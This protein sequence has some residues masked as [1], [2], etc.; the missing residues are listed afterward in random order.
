MSRK[1]C[2]D[3]VI[4]EL[5]K[6]TAQELDTILKKVLTLIR[7]AKIRVIK[8]DQKRTVPDNRVTNKDM[9]YA[10]GWLTAF[11]ILWRASNMLDCVWLI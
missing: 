10:L 2:D 11:S 8:N 4:Q 1:N 5:R 7:R 6:L 9:G 3:M